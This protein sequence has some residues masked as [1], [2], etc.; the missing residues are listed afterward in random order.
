MTAYEK[1]YLV[2]QAV[3]YLLVALLLGY[4]AY[5]MYKKKKN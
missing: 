1:G 2:G 4:I 3:G 5:R